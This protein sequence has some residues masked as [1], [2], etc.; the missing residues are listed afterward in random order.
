MGYDYYF[1]IQ[2]LENETWK[3]LEYNHYSG[4][5]KNSKNHYFF[6]EHNN[7]N[8]SE[9][10][11]KGERDLGTYQFLFTF[12]QIKADKKLYKSEKQLRNIIDFIKTQC[13]DFI[14]NDKI[15]RDDVDYLRCSID[16]AYGASI[17][18]PEGYVNELNNFYEIC[19]K[20]MNTNLYKDCRIIFGITY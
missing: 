11:Y 8:E 5:Y 2:C 14:K 7:D 16:E 15:T 12:E 1:L 6:E 19:Q 13:E 3:D 18:K 20:Y 4:S 17:E 10:H 9:F